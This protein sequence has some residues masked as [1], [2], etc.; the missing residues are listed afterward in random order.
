MISVVTHDDI[1]RVALSLPGSYEQA[2]YGGRP[3]WPTKQR[4]FTWIRED[5]EALVVWVDSADETDALV[6][7][8]PDTFLT[9]QHYDGQPIVLARLEAIDAQEA[10]ELITESWRL[11]APRADVRA[12]DATHR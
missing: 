10:A 12:W 1:R 6:A 7:S 3:S 8:E 4:M 2:S 5:P 9:T 11:R